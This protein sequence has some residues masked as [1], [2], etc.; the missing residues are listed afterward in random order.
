MQEIRFSPDETIISTNINDDNSLYLI[1]KGEVTVHVK[2][3]VL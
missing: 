3:T 1:C 2:D